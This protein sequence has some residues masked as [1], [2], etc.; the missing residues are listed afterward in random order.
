MNLSPDAT[1][2]V[3]LLISLISIIACVYT[4]FR[5][6]K[7]KAAEDAQGIVKANVKLDAI[8]QQVGEM[9]QDMKNLESRFNNVEKRLENHEMRITT[10]ESNSRK[11]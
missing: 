6:V 4:F 8:C 3:S 10:L 11:S 1:I 7:V 5:S 2:S 9:R